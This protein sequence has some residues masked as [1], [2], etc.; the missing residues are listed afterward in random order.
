MLRVTRKVAWQTRRCKP[1]SIS[2][3]ELL[4]PPS[5]HLLL[6]I[7]LC[8][9]ALATIHRLQL[10]QHRHHVG[11]KK[12]RPQQYSRATERSHRLPCRK[13][14]STLP[15]SHTAQLTHSR[16]RTTSQ[17]PRFV[18]ITTAGDSRQNMMRRMPERVHQMLRSNRTRT[19]C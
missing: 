16:R 5:V 13:S 15:P 8:N 6:N 12:R 11:Q 1:L 19:K 7:T 3:S 4:L 2:S 17:P 9:C 10:Q 14:T 18:M